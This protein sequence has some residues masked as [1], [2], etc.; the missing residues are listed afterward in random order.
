MW[1]KI[2]LTAAT[3]ALKLLAPKASKAV[4]T[5]QT[6]Q[7]IAKLALPVVESVSRF[8]VSNA[9]KFDLALGDVSKLAAEDSNLGV[10]LKEHILESGVQLAYSIVKSKIG[11]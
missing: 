10:N 3:I 5:V 6:I 8:D 1:Q 9:T 2:A 11:K 7:T 4:E